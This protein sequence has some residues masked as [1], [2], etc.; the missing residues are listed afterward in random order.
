MFMQCVGQYYKL[1]QE[2]IAKALA[3]GRNPE[4]VTII[5]VTKKQPLS[6]IQECY[7]AGCRLFGES[8]ILEALEKINEMPNDVKWHLIGTLQSNKVAK[9]LN[10]PISLIHSVDS[11]FLAKK[12]SEGSFQRNKQTSILLQVNVSG[13]VS[14]KG[15]TPQ[16]WEKGLEALQ[17]LSHLSIEGL[18]TMA[19]HTNDQGVIRR[20]FRELF[21][22]REKWKSEMNH[23]YSFKQLSMGM[24]NDYLIAIEEGATLLRIGSAIFDDHISLKI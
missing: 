5:P 18:M 15:L 10:A 11:L 13:E 3:C 19:P 1:Q 8:R 2:V 16:E 9:V 20:C 17:N 21:E 7:Q 14:K 4:E 23:P 12:I 24:T 22:L 6:V